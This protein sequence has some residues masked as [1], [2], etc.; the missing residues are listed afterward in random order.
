M[1]EYY[2]QIKSR[3]N[4]KIDDCCMGK[5]NFPPLMSG[6]VSG[7]DINDA[8]SKLTNYMVKISPL[9]Y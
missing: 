4:P 1:A 8:K 5:W 3:H 9:G 7:I 2:Y 6:K